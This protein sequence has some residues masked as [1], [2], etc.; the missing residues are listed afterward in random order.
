MPS[1]TLPRFQFDPSQSQFKIPSDDPA[2]F[3][4]AVSRLRDQSYIIRLDW[5]GKTIFFS[6][7]QEHKEI[8]P[9][10]FEVQWTLYHSTNSTID[11]EAF[12]FSSDDERDK[13]IEL[14]LAVLSVFHGLIPEHRQGATIKVLQPKR[15]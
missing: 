11:A 6:A 12:R 5:R 14:E 3:A 7:L 1:F 15:R 13:A 9:K 10:I 4:E 8:L 2:I